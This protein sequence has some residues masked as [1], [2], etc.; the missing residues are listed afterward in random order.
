MKSVLLLAAAF[1]ASVITVKLAV[2]L[3]GGRSRGLS[4]CAAA[5]VNGGI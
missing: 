4:S 5:G 1:A 2:E 3:V